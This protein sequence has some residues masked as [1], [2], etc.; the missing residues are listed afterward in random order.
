MVGANRCERG[1]AGCNDGCSYHGKSDGKKVIEI[2]E[3]MES[4]ETR[5]Y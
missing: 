4:V 2:N 5:E 3:E 1:Q